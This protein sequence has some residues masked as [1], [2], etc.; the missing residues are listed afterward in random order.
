VQTE[1]FKIADPLA[2]P[3][4]RYI[5]QEN[6]ELRGVFKLKKS[7]VDPYFNIKPA[8]DDEEDGDEC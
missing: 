6:P 8:D 2:A 1:G 5:M 7:E 4:A 3:Y